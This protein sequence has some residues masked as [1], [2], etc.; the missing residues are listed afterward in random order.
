MERQVISPEGLPDSEQFKYSQGIIENG[1][2]FASGQPAWDT[3]FEVQG[4]DIKT[5]TR[6]ALENVGVLL[7]AIDKNYANITKVTSYV[8]KPQERIEDVVSVWDEFFDS[9]YPCHTMIGVDQLAIEGFLIELEIEVPV[10][11]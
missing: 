7:D 1:T 8:L 11:E 3:N 6:K 10:D 5:Q 4:D 9:P 2:F